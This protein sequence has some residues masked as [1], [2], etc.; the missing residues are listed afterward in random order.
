VLDPLAPT[1][2]DDEATFPPLVQR[3]IANA[4]D[5][6]FPLRRDPGTVG[7]T[8]SLPGVGR[9]LATLAAAVPPGG[10]IG[11]IGT[12]AGVGAAWIATGMRDDVTL[13][14]VEVDAQFAAAAQR[15]F[16]GDAR[17]TVVHGDAND[18]VPQHAPFDLL[19]VDGGLA[20]TDALV[21]LVRVGGHLVVDDVTPQRV[22][23]PGS[24]FVRDDQKRALFF[25]S[26]R[27]NGVEVVLPDLA[28]SAL[29]ATRVS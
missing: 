21:D 4:H 23:P 24:E 19:F 10:R 16:A 20:I 9:L 7:H 6:G 3:A 5:L 14:T 13:L 26:P 27:L 22:L 11:E 25:G 18:V 15:L 17:I 12:A 1:D 28:N 8:S 2:L 29:L